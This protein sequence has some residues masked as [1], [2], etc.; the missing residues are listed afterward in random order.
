MSPILFYGIDF[1]NGVGMNNE[2]NNN[3]IKL[4]QFVRNKTAI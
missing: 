4:L 3:R 1:T 2:H